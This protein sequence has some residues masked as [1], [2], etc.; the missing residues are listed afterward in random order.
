MSGYLKRMTTTVLLVG[1]GIMLH[2]QKQVAITID[3]V[4]NSV[5]CRN[6]EYYSPLLQTLDQLKI[7]V[8]IF[9][10]EGK[11][12]KE[13]L[14]ES[15][16][17]KLLDDWIG[18]KYTTVGN[19][20]FGHKRYSDLGLDSFVADIERGTVRNRLALQHGKVLRYFRFPF[21]DLGKDSL[22]H[23]Q[24]TQY[25]TQ[26]GYC[27]TPFTIENSDWAYS[28]VYE[29]WLY[30]KDRAK[31][32]KVAQE[33]ISQT[34]AYFTYFEA[35]S[36]ELYNRPVIHIYLCHDNAL[37]AKCLPVLIRLL[38]DKGYKFISLDEAMRD[39][40][41]QQKDRYNK[42]FG[43]SWMYRWMTDKEQAMRYLKGQPDVD[44]IENLRDSLMSAYRDG[45]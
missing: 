36:R 19:H 44:H 20:T 37:N 14:S 9:I 5:I 18:K 31:A 26:H 41:Y 8:A 34:M 32:E 43:I 23:A 40:V 29:Y 22:Q 3:D 11:M 15:Q 45:Y 33:Y 1:T 42:K 25:L 10:N 39:E 12:Y 6:K 13:G 17:I 4:P 28:D 24:I 16:G 35:I 21:N 38:K 7:P 30:K 27:I 2:A